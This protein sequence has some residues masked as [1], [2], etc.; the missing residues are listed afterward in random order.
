MKIKTEK[1]NSNGGTI[2]YGFKVDNKRLV[3]DKEIAEI[4]KEIFKM[5]SE[6]NSKSKIINTFKNRTLHR[7]KKI[8]LGVLSNMLSNKKYIGIYHFNDIEVEGGCPAIIDI[9]L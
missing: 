3:N 2:P 1:A 9:N 8:S 4:V 5:Y 6:G 7:G